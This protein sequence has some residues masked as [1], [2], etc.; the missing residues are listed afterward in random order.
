M[1]IRDRGMWIGLTLGL[2]ISAAFV[3][4]RVNYTTGAGRDKF[5]LRT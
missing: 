5:T 1:C 3:I 2:F 4:A